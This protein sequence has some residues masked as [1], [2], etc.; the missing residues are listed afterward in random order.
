MPNTIL[1]IIIPVYNVEQYIDQCIQSIFAQKFQ[2]YEIILVDDGSTDNSGQ[3]CESYAQKDKR[4]K[5]THKTNGGVSSARNIGLQKANG[6][7][8]T[9][10]DPDDFIDENTFK[11][12]MDIILKN[13]EIDILQYPFCRYYNSEHIE[14]ITPPIRQYIKGKEEIFSNWWSGTPIHYSTCNKIFKKEIFSNITFLEG[15]VSEDTRLII[16]FY[17]KIKVIYLSEK[18]RY[19]YRKREDSLTSNYSYDKHLDLFQAHLC[20]YAE[21]I[22]YP[23]LASKKVLAFERMFRRLIQA[24]QSNS[25]ANLAIEFQQLNKLFPNWKD[26]LNSQGNNKAWIFTAKIIGSKI[27]TKLFIYYLKK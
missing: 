20:I 13:S 8:L 22:K 12:N 7:Y 23:S 9:F 25:S 21:L 24:Q 10:I 19:Y 26:I 16:D 27:F 17:K 5:V 6:K 2:G 3:I 11:D 14:I 4:V 1:S 15:H 18:G